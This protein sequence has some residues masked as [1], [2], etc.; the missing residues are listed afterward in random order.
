SPAEWSAHL[1]AREGRKAPETAP[2]PDRLAVE[3]SDPAATDTI[4]EKLAGQYIGT[5][6]N[7]E[8]REELAADLSELTGTGRFDALNYELRDENGETVLLIRTNETNGRPT[9]PTRIDIGFDVNSFESENVS[10]NVVARLTYFD[11][12]RY[13]AE[14]RND[15]RIGSNT[16]LASE[17]FRPIGKTGVFV[18]PRV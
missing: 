9:D 11:V 14:W 8:A 12:G 18:A 6:L 10:F 7:E 13:G 16:L 1:A 4:E 5:E 17:Y 3:G 2:V 15:L